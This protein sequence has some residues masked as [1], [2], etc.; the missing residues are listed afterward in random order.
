[1]FLPGCCL[2]FVSSAATSRLISVVG[3]QSG[4]SRVLD[5]TTFGALVIISACG[6]RAGRYED[7]PWT[8]RMT[9]GSVRAHR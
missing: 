7:Q 9:N 3:P 2:S 1:M 8:I 4:W 6:M 5:T